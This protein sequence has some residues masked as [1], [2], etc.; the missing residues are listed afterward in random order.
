VGE[1]EWEREAE[2]WVRWARTPG[3]DP[4]W[5][6]R[7]SF[8]DAILP[9]PGRRTLEIGCGEGR[10]ARDLADR[11][12][13]VTALDTAKALVRSARDAD[14]AGDYLVAESAVLPFARSCFDIVVAYNALQ[15]VADMA[16]TVHEAARVL[17][18]GGY[19]CFC[20]AHPT[21]DLGAF[22]GD[23]HDAAYT[24]RSA[25]FERTRVEETVERDGLTMTFRG[26]TYTLEDYALALA[27]AGFAIEA[28][29]EPKP[30]PAA[31][32]Y[33]RWTRVPL[34]MNVRAAKR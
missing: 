33:E 18:S 29:Q 12:H 30:D 3:H 19:F 4:Y 25:Y 15:V 11:G 17:T 6:Y 16:G 21:T 32:R 26:W 28:I 24:I 9:P 2:N 7:A 34:F 10:V 1:G 31:G 27:D 22:V 5:L 13:R 20:V 14:V 8:F 23:E